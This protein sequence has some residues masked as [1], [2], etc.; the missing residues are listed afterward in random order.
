MFAFKCW[1]TLPW[2]IRCHL[3]LLSGTKILAKRPTSFRITLLWC[4]SSRLWYDIFQMLSILFQVAA[5]IWSSKIFQGMEYAKGG[6][7]CSTKIEDSKIHSHINTYINSPKWS[8]INVC[9]NVFRR[10]LNLYLHIYKCR[11]L[12]Y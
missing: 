3:R 7:K 5:I 4:I 1:I 8:W 12:R 9:K 6:K 10:Y 2:C 11:Y